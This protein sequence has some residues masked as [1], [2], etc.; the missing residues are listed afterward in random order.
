[1]GSRWQREKERE[2]EE[3]RAAGPVK[4]VGRGGGSWAAGASRPGRGGWRAGPVAGQ[5][6]PSAETGQGERREG[7]TGPF[8]H[9]GLSLSFF[10]LISNFIFQSL[11]QI[12]F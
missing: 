6:G 7:K 2:K 11:F 10:F 5:L 1:M 12:E 9:Q 4:E 3:G 8:G